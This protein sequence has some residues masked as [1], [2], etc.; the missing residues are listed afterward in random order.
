MLDIQEFGDKLKEHGYGFYAG[1][2]CSFLKHLINH[3]INCMDYVIAANEGDAVAIASGAYLGG[4]KSV[5]LMQNSGLTNAV[6]PLTSLNYI[7]Q[8]PVLGFVSLRGETGLH[9]EP[10]HELMGV[11]TSEMLSLMKVR[12]EVLSSDS[13][14]AAEQLRRADE[15]M[16]ETK[17]SFFFVVK[18]KTFSEEKLKQ[19]LEFKEYQKEVVDKKTG[20]VETTRLQALEVISRFKDDRTALLAN[21]GKAGRELFEIQ[22]SEHNFYMVGSMGCISP[23]ALGLAMVK[24]GKRIIAID[25]DGA[26][27]MRLGT[28]ATNGFYKP[29]NM[30]HILLDN[31]SHDSTG[32]QST[33]SGNVNFTQV[34]HHAGYVRSL[35]ITGL[36]DLTTQIGRWKEDPALTFLNMRIK[37]GSKKDLGR[38][39]IKPYEVKERLMTFLSR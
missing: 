17:G 37:K 31:S 21:T 38:P 18:D 10:Q 1:V 33:V 9:D 30:L 36:D 13:V 4:R 11:I 6:S 16:S 15:Y 25:G 19:T 32:G 8:I 23:V 24:P 29:A 20:P 7:F 35:T 3:C 14:Q 39:T 5:V 2:P 34:A 28:L 27:L 22:D 12:N 26:V